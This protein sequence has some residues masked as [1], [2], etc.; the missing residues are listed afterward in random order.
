[1]NI[2]NKLYGISLLSLL[3]SVTACTSETEEPFKGSGTDTLPDETRREVML[4]LKNK[5]SVAKTKAGDEI[6]TAAENKI[7]S[8]DI[9]V[10]GSKTE[11]GTYTYQERLCYR[12][13][14]ADM[15]SGSEITAFELIAKGNDGKETTAL[16]TLKKGLFVK[17]YC[18]A[19]QSKLIDPATGAAYNSFV[20]LTQS[21]PGQPGN[22]V[23]D[24]T[25]KEADFK[26]F[27][28]I[29]LDPATAAD[30]LTTP[31]PM[32]GA[33][34]TPLDLTDFS[35][36]AR[37]QLG[38]R[39]TRSVARF[40][41]INDAAASRF[42][43][44]SVS[45]ANG[46]KGVSLFPLKVTGTLPAAGGDLITYPARPFDGEKANEGTCTGAFYIWPSP[47][48]DGGY[49]ILSGTYATNQTENTPVTYKVPFKPEGDGN[50]IEVSQNHRYTVNITKADEYHLDFT[51]DVADW[52]DEGNIDDYEPGG[53]T[54]GE[55]MTVIP[56]TGVEYDKTLRT[57]T[58]ALDEM[59]DF[60]ITGSSAGGYFVSKYY[61][62]ND[63]THD[64]LK[65]IGPDG[66]IETKA[67]NGASEY[68][69]SLNAN[70]HGT[71][72][73]LA[74]LRFTDKISA[75]ESI[76]MIQA[77]SAPRFEMVVHSSPGASYIN[78]VI[79][80]EAKSTIQTFDLDLKVFSAIG[81][82]IVGLPDWL[83][84]SPATIAETSGNYK[85]AITTLPDPFLQTAF[86]DT[87]FDVINLSDERKKTEIAVKMTVNNPEIVTAQ[88]TVVGESSG[89]FS[90]YDTA[91]KKMYLF[92]DNSE[93]KLTIFSLGGCEV[94]N[95]PSWMTVTPGE[96]KNTMELTFKQK[97][98]PTL[99]DISATIQ[100][101]NKL[102][103]TKKT[104]ITVYNKMLGVRFREFYGSNSY[105]YVEGGS[106]ITATTPS[107]V[108]FPTQK[109]Y[110]TF[111]VRTP[112]GISVADNTQWITTPFIT[113]TQTLSNGD[114]LSTVKVTMWSNISADMCNTRRKTG[115]ITVTG[116]KTSQTKKMNIK[117]EHITYNDPNATNPP[118]LASTSYGK[119]WTYVKGSFVR[120]QYNTYKQ[121]PS[122]WGLMKTSSLTYF[123]SGHYYDT[124]KNGENNL[125][126][127]DSTGDM[128][129]AFSIIKD[130][131]AAVGDSEGEF[132]HIEPAYT[133]YV[134]GY[135]WGDN[136]FT[137][138]A[139]R[140]YND[141]TDR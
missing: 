69:V 11:D 96:T 61:V 58:V 68:T 76:M 134:L 88:P 83:T 36:S 91:N 136:G 101:Q 89:S 30:I 131:Y 78:N 86:D 97:T 42:T 122:G 107:V 33:Y 75:K 9:Y 19:N 126:N 127:F 121:C 119:Y 41:I 43:I 109:N 94:M 85:F 120:S 111:K 71:D 110:F 25:P 65:I 63:K 66:V 23:T 3:L 100:I 47:V 132:L 133:R 67:G 18:V 6:A 16:L 28:S 59:A 90:Y 8:L 31:L 92:G 103:N 79:T 10:F 137:V 99:E 135:A 113:E 116:I 123:L 24:G 26:L 15:P 54:D 124:N 48:E 118:T 87:K 21:A 114:I 130:E 140:A 95:V 117:T 5:L 74:F 56:A 98:V 46:R 60:K 53:E 20:P 32:T 77:I 12:E 39:L 55:G 7:L 93:V 72:F 138:R 141:S 29:Q 22:V 51:I 4:T 115:V 44:Q 73:P 45:M 70:Y 62:D 80:F 37:L 106:S 64:W 2:V 105:S 128:N 104:A 108:Y 50:Y 38:F 84:V 139:W 35:V 17:L 49:L 52:T 102:D 82:K 125:H 14:S 112:F 57:I 34:T 13:N 129:R 1:M 27:Q 40:D 81:S